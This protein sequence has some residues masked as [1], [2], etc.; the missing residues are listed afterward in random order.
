MKK[1]TVD[2]LCPS[3]WADGICDS[4]ESRVYYDTKTFS[5]DEAFK[6]A[7]N[8]MPEINALDECHGSLFFLYIEGHLVADIIK[9]KGIQ[10][11]EKAVK[12]L[13]LYLSNP[14][15]YFKILDE[16]LKEYVSIFDKVFKT[17]Q[18]FSL[19]DF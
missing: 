7:N 10:K 19:E 9:N 15:A 8:K 5:V 4:Y 6:W 3:E 2:I 11:D 13:N 17:K 18:N 14:D 1:L 16:E 12:M